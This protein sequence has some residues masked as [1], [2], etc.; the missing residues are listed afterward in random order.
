M[1]TKSAHDATPIRWVLHADMD[2]FFASVEQRDFPELADVNLVVGGDGPRGV[3]AAASYNAR[4]FGIRSA[5]PMRAAHARCPDLVVRRGRM[6]VYRRE[7]KRVFEIFRRFTP[8]VEGLSLDEAFLDVTQSLALFESVGA[9]AT[10]LKAAVKDEL[11]L[12]VSV[13][14]APNKLVAKIASD[15]D[16]PDG[17]V[18]V[19]GDAVVATL[20]PL[21]ARVLPGI[22][23]RT[24]ERV[25][26]AGLETLGDIRR[27][28]GNVLQQV[29]GKHAESMRRRASG[30]DDRDVNNERIEK[31][32][33][34]ERTFDIDL[35]E[36]SDID[37][38]LT[39]LAEKTARRLRDSGNQSSVVTVK[40]RQ[41]DFTTVTRQQRLRPPTDVTDMILESAIGLV[42]RWLDEHRDARIRLLGIG[43]GGLSVA[44]QADLFGEPDTSGSAVDAT[45]DEVTDRFGLGALTRASALERPKLK[46]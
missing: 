14:A 26:A 42:H 36:R 9:I 10:E 27:A 3:V 33:S 2:A 20:D 35:V 18:V 6:D 28:S 31:S 29:F 25:S 39:R 13:G 43:V 30:I 4:R 21:S 40:I 23:P 15:L 7:S 8:L 38:E 32:I 12:T 34:A 37:A 1:T 17:L 22:G 44:R 16:K 24:G 46:R 41:H 11:D 5:M 19:P 45:V